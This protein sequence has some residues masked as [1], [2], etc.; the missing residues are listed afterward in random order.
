MATGRDK[1]IKLLILKFI[2][3]VDSLNPGERLSIRKVTAKRATRTSKRKTA[4][5][6][7]DTRGEMRRSRKDT[8]R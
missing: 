4:G 7:A 1:D 2:K 8:F 6:P 5:Q 3:L